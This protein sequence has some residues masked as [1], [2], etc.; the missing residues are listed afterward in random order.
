MW[1][2][3]A[4]HVTALVCC[5]TSLI[6]PGEEVQLHQH[7]LLG[8]IFISQ[9]LPDFRTDL[10]MCHSTTQASQVVL[11]VKNSPDDARD[12]RD[13]GFHPWVGKIPWRK[14]W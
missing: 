7:Q 12:E 1:R 6:W 4:A 13:S 8:G 10:I 14:A 3:G 2:S 5:T 9:M 11:V